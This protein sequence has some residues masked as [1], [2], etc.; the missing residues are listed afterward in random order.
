MARNSLLSL[1]VISFLAVFREGAETVL[2]YVGIAP[3]IA[4]GDLVLG[5]AI[6]TAG[7][8]VLG[9]IM[10]VFGVRIP[11]RPFFLGTSILILYLAFKFIGAGIHAL[12]V[13]GIFRATPAAYLPSNGFL[14]LFPTWET[15]V[16]QLVLL[17]GAMAVVLVSRLRKTDHVAQPRRTL[18]TG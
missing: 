16:P 12:Q 3:S 5:L 17:L 13:A 8:A 11:I 18:R 15:T 4:T 2:F 14:G 6:G 9:V 10:L 7:L 1:A